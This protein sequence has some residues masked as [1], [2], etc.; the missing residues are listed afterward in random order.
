LKYFP[1]CTEESDVPIYEYRCAAC[2]KKSSRIWMR[3]PAAAEERALA[4]P[5]CSRSGRA[6]LRDPALLRA[7]RFLVANQRQDG[8]WGEDARA[9][10]D[11]RWIDHAET[12]SVNTAWALL[13]LVRAGCTDHAAIRRAV[14]WPV[15]HQTT[16]G[17]WPRQAILGVFN[18]T[19]AINYDNYRRYF[20][21]W[22]LGEWLQTRR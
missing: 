11:G 12:Q 3:L 15:A 6:S 13:T 1:T 22:A 4:C 18:R 19:T 7:C 16:E 14:E 8:G 10:R 17:C 5:V 2:Q 20:P 9:C 21:V